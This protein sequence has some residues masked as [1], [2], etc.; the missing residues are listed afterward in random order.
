[1]CKNSRQRFWLSDDGIPDL[2]GLM[3]TPIASRSSLSAI[4]QFDWQ[5]KPRASARSEV[6]AYAAQALIARIISVMPK[7]RITR[8]RL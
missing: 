6:Q 2:G 7:M 3:P 4:V 1:L 5:M 8:F